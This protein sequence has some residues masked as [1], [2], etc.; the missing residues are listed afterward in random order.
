MKREENNETENSAN[1]Y[2]FLKKFTKFQGFL[3]SVLYKY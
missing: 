3:C 2:K 1:V